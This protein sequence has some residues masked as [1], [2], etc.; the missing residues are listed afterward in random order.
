MVSELKLTLSFKFLTFKLSTPCDPLDCSPPVFSVHGI[1]LVRILVWVAITFSRNLPD[2]EIK[3]GS[4]A[5]QSDSL[6]SELQGEPQNRKYF[7]R[8]Q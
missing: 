7:I 8:L 6:P 5:L 2:P 4:P 3:P 1:L